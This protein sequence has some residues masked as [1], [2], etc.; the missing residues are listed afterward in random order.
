MA[1]TLQSLVGR[2]LITCISITTNEELGIS[3]TCWDSIGEVTALAMNS[4]PTILLRNTCAGIMELDIFKIPVRVLA[5]RDV[6]G[7]GEY[8]ELVFG[9]ID[10]SEKEVKGIPIKPNRVYGTL[11]QGLEKNEKIE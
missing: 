5:F 1:I 11:P 8:L 4:T 9:N 3:S 7:E 6:E 10:G 2:P